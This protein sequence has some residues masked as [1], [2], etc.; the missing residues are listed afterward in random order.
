MVV[1]NLV[2]MKI[3][4]LTKASMMARFILNTMISEAVQLSADLSELQMAEEALKNEDDLTLVEDE[5]NHAQDDIEDLINILKEVDIESRNKIP[6]K[7]APKK[8]LSHKQQRLQDAAKSSKKITEFFSKTRKPPVVEK[9]EES[10]MEWEDD[11]MEWDDLPTLSWSAIERMENNRE[12]ARRCRRAKIQKQTLL[13]SLERKNQERLEISD[14]IIESWENSWKTTR[15][16]TV[17]NS[18]D[19]AWTVAIK[20]SINKGGWERSGN[21]DAKKHR[22]S[23]RLSVDIKP[24]EEVIQQEREQHT[25]ELQDWLMGNLE[26]EIDMSLAAKMFNR[27]EKEY[28]HMLMDL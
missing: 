26:E 12:K 20:H 24:T 22:I 3:T 10:V 16:E 17:V 27:G 1:R 18:S 4:P 8:R 7:P 28:E 9:K 13:Q 2:Q 11:T 25:Q 14:W 6:D 15:L 21:L 5:V 19:M 23:W